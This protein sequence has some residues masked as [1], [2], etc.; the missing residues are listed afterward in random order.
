HPEGASREAPIGNEPDR[1]T[2]S[3]ADD[4]GGWRQHL[5]HSRP[6]ARALVADDQDVARLDAAGEDRFEAI[7][8]GFEHPSG[9]GQFA[10]LDASDFC[11]RAFGREVTSKNREM[12]LRVDRPAPRANH[13]LI[14]TRLD[15]NLC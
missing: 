2:Q 7:L 13:L 6:T 9:P 10:L 14:P 8:L 11:D 12:T 1:I 15:R 5:S 3:S 4:C